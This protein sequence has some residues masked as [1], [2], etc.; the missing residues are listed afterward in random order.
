[1]KLYYKNETL[2]IYINMILNEENYKIIK[3]RIFKIVDDYEIN[4]IVI[5]SC[6]SDLSSKKLFH[7]IKLE[8]QKKYAG[9]FSI[10]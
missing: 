3:R 9:H 2:F 5:R 1:M 4:H 8:Y 10:K 7:K 6:D